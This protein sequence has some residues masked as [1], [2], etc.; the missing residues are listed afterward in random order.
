MSLP[1]PTKRLF[2]TLMFGIGT[3]ALAALCSLFDAGLGTFLI[4][5]GILLG[6]Y[7]ILTCRLKDS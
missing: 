5:W 3:V 1:V 6:I 4:L 2:S 7:G